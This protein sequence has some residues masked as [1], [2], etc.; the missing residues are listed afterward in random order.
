[1]S[2]DTGHSDALQALAALLRCAV[3]GSALDPDCVA[4]MDLD[5]AFALAQRHM[6]S[7]AAACALDDAGVKHEGFRHAWLESVRKSMLF[8]AEM[9][10]VL[11]ALDSAGIPY[12]PLKGAVLQA[13]YPRYGMR[14]MADRDIL[15]DAGQAGEVRSIMESRGYRLA[16]YGQESHDVYEK[17]PVFSFEMHRR[18]FD[19]IRAS[20]LEWYY[21]D[22]WE[23]LIPDRPGGCAYHFSPEDF[24]VYILA[25]AYKHCNLGGTGLRIVV[26]MH[27]MLRALSGKVNWEIIA[28][29]T[30]RLGIA[31]F[32]RTL[33]GLSDHFFGG[34]PLS[35]A[36]ADMLDY[37]CASGAFGVLEHSVRNAVDQMGG[38]RIGKLRFVLRRLFI[39]MNIVSEVYPFFHRHRILLPALYVYRAVKMLTVSR[40]KVRREL[41]AL[42]EKRD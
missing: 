40:N 18:L 38:G 21:R 37:L 19:T 13:W 17:P 4:R 24:Y 6:L 15:I 23:R 30:G 39:P 1:M 35:Q 34:E 7:A 20:S 32:E 9:A 12:V 5:A 25:H 33:R 16:P 10:E 22:P 8:D 36:E 26:D 41:A 31:D 2:Q 28:A 29:E 3:D 27:V 14:E 42:M 11:S